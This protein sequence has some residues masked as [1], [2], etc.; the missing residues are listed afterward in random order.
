MFNWFNTRPKDA[1]PKVAP[2]NIYKCPVELM[3][4]TKKTIPDSSIADG[5]A[6]FTIG[7]TADGRTELRLDKNLN[8]SLSLVM[9]TATVVD[10]IE[11]LACS[12]RKDYQVEVTPLPLN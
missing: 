9:T 8:N 10:L 4:V 1:Y 5:K 6:M 11:T 2:Q 3:N 12:I 7:K